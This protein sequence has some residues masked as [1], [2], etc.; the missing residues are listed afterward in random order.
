MNRQV[1]VL[2]EQV[3]R[4]IFLPDT[5]AARNDDH[6]NVILHGCQNGFGFIWHDFRTDNDAAIPRKPI[7]FALTRSRY[8]RFT[9]CRR[10]RH[11]SGR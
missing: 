9:R 6:V 11:A 4:K 8:P 1:T 2:G 7:P 3:R 10:V 5:R